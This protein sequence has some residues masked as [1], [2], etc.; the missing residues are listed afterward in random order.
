MSPETILYI[1][2]AAIVSFGISSF[3]YGYRSKYTGRLRWLFAGLRSVTLFSLLLLLLNPKF[4]STTFVNTKPS[5]SVVTDNSFSIKAAGKDLEVKQLLEG[6]KNNGALNKAFD[7]SYYTLG[8]ELNA[9]DSLSFSE[10][11]TNI[12]KALSQTDA[13]GKGAVA[14]TVLITDG[15]QTLGSDY[16][17]SSASLKQQVFPLIVGDSTAFTD[18]KISQLNS[19]RYAFLKNNFPVEATVVYTGNGRVRSK[20]IVAQGS[21]TVF[22]QNLTFSE[23]DNAQTVSFNLRANSVGV[24]KYT[25]Q[26]VPLPDE[27]NKTNNVAPFA[28]EVVDQATNVLVV[29]DISHPDLGALKKAVQRNEQRTLT[30]KKPEGAVAGLDDY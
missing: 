13:L 28:V 21:N 25:A 3:M 1:V 26:I 19:N 14:P 18:L 6:F 27:K 30:L 4:T 22:T 8:E 17:F 29:S 11:N 2:I 20:F 23:T 15:N 9:L 5:L 16:E 24:Q 10:Q 12:A 7:I